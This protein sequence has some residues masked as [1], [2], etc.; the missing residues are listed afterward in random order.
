LVKNWATCVYDGLLNTRLYDSSSILNDIWFSPNPFGFDPNAYDR[1]ITIGENPWDSSVNQNEIENFSD[2]FRTAYQTL[3][4]TEVSSS[5]M[6]LV[7]S[8][9]GDNPSVLDWYIPS[10]VEMNHIMKYQN[11]INGDFNKLN[12]TY[13][14]STTGLINA[15]NLAQHTDFDLSIDYT[16]PETEEERYRIG[17]ARY[18]YAQ[19]TDGTISSP[20][21]SSLSAKVR[22]VKRVPIYVVSK[23]CYTPNAFPSIIQCN[24]S[25]SCPCGGEQIV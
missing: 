14:T 19:H 9:N 17:S 24:Q 16:I 25:G 2:A 8:A 15:H 5:A 6:G 11:D 20:L 13:W 12:G 22:L 23:Y 4:N 3:W 10:L 18:A 7:S 21:K 1:W